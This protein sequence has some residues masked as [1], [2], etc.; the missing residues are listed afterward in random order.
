MLVAPNNVIRHP[1]NRAFIEKYCAPKQ[2][3]GEAP[4]QPR[5]G[6]QRATDAPPP[7]LEFTSA[8]PQKGW[9]IAYDTWTTSRRP[10]TKPKVS[11]STRPVIDKSSRVRLKTLKNRY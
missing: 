8:H 11:K 10:S 1:I 4:Q 3:Q 2:A 5:D 7:P 9:S 6:Q